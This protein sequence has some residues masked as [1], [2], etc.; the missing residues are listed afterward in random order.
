MSIKIQ[1]SHNNHAALYTWADPVMLVD[2]EYAFNTIG[3]FYEQVRGP[4]HS[5]FVAAGQANLPAHAINTFLTHPNSQ[6][7][8][9][10][11]GLLFLV[12]SGDFVSTNLE[13][14]N[15]LGISDRIIVCETLEE[16]WEKLENVLE[17]EVLPI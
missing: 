6:F 17:E 3:A 4:I 5:I 8:S 13:L 15:L 1:F 12:A 11:T 7:Q 2:F 14:T 9:T 10:N 16:A